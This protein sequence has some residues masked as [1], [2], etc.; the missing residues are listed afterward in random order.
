MLKSLSINK[1]HILMNNCRRKMSNMHNATDLMSF[2]CD[3][4]IFYK[5]DLLL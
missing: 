2:N 3:V 4:Y 1:Y 5:K